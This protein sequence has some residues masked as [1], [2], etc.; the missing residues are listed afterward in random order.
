MAGPA[1]AGQRRGPWS[2]FEDDLLMTLIQN[3]GCSNWVR[4]SQE[5]GS[6]S[7]KQCRERYHQNLNP[8]LNHE[9]ITKEEGQLIN[10][11]VDTKGKRW[12]EIAR[13]LHGRCD[14][15]VK[16]WWNGSQNK[17]RRQNR[18]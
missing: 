8:S 1:Q 4:I 16:N 15:S 9:P 10:Y 11:L 3:H 18:R 17:R 12:A 6:R 5:L 2:Q 13:Q 7:A 14:N